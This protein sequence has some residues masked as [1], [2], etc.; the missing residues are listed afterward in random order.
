MTWA[1]KMKMMMKKPWSCEEKKIEECNGSAN[2]TRGT[3]FSP[4]SVVAP[5]MG[6]LPHTGAGD[7]LHY[8]VS[9]TSL[10]EGL[11]KDDACTL[12]LAHDVISLQPSIEL[13]LD[14]Y[15]PVVEPDESKIDC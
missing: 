5:I 14:A 7:T 15:P 12:L 6:G 11:S 2:M 10:I 4:A 1:R 3:K 9:D 8:I 13:C